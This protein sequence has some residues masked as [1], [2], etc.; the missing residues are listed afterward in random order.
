MDR[1]HT[2]TP[3]AV[4][5]VGKDAGS[6]QGQ[7]CPFFRGR[8]RDIGN[9]WNSQ[10]LSCVGVGASRQDGSS[11]FA[12]CTVRAALPSVK[13][14]PGGGVSLLVETRRGTSQGGDIGSDVLRRAYAGFFGKAQSEDAEE[15]NNRTWQSYRTG[16]GSETARMLFKRRSDIMQEA[17]VKAVA[18]NAAKLQSAANCDTGSAV[19]AATLY[20]AAKDMAT[21]AIMAGGESAL[22]D[23]QQPENSETPEAAHSETVPGPEAAGPTQAADY[24]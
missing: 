14:S 23:S 19:V 17:T 2:A 22:P 10:D 24:R 18:A 8:R 21:G 16:V 13:V 3:K 9:G 15:M 1:V 20:Q 11:D 12:G 5:I 7:G 4:R 6:T